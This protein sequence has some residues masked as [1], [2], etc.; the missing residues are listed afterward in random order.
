VLV[1]NVGTMLE[2]G[3]GR[4]NNVIIKLKIALI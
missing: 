4:S 1:L 3:T 2:T